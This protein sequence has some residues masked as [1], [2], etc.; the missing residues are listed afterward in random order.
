MPDATSDVP[1][2]REDPSA[3]PEAPAWDLLP[4]PQPRPVDAPVYQR[5]THSAPDDVVI[6]LI[7]R[8]WLPLALASTFF[9]LM[10]VFTSLFNGTM[11]DPIVLVLFVPLFAMAALGWSQVI[12]SPQ[13]RVGSEGFVLTTFGLSP[14]SLTVPW[15]DVAALRLDARAMRKGGYVLHLLVTPRPGGPLASPLRRVVDIP[16]GMTGITKVHRAL[17]SH[18]PP[19]YSVTGD[20]H[21]RW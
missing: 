13:L 15:A 9:C 6:R 8:F 1:L 19:R 10:A 18:R 5:P 21:L 7:S 12:R 17:R 2:E 11:P 4:P 14:A 3:A 20:P 16:L